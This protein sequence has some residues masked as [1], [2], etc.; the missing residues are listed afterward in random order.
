[1]TE[2]DKVL[3]AQ[4]AI[5][6]IADEL[7]K[8]GSASELINKSKE[9]SEAILQS[10][11]EIIKRAG[12]FTTSSG[13]ILNRLGS[14]DLEQK[15]QSLNEQIDQTKELI[16]RNGNTVSEV[17]RKQF[18]SLSEVLDKNLDSIKKTQKQIGE[19]RTSLDEGYEKNDKQI[20]KIQDEA[21]KNQAALFEEI[22]N[23][24]KIVLGASVLII[25]AIIFVIVKI[26]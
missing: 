4:K 13:E 24:K 1:M 2:I 20:K 26:Y 17:N 6:S 18:D 23:L 5:E 10:S 21:T 9:A 25:V 14:I 7:T 19:I 3:E 22:V 8:L 11:Q 15:L 12:D 16:R